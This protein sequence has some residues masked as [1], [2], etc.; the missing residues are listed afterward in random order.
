M[1][2]NKLIY[3]ITTLIIISISAR[4]IYINVNKESIKAEN[5][6][7]GDIAEIGDNFFDSSDELMNGYSVKILSSEIVKADDYLKKYGH[8]VDEQFYDDL[9]YYYIVRVSVRN[10]NNSYVGE[11]GINFQRWY[12]EGSDYILRIEDYAYSLANSIEGNS[13][14]ISLR[15]DSEMEFEL[16]FYVF[17]ESHSYNKLKN[18]FSNLVITDYPVKIKMS[19]N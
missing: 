10:K 7:K 2:K 14:S 8:S 19:L 6:A 11:K 16:P 12:I 9:S 15:E 5:I 13:L 17:S 4:I 1:M 3:I 18:D